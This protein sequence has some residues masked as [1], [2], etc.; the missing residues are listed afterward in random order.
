MGQAKLKNKFADE[1]FIQLSSLASNPDS[2]E[3]F[4]N[5]LNT[6]G[7]STTD[8]AKF[9]TAETTYLKALSHE[10]ELVKK[11]LTSFMDKFLSINF[12]GENSAIVSLFCEIQLSHND[13]IS[14]F[15]SDGGLNQAA[16]TCIG[17]ENATMHLQPF[18]VT[19]WAKP[20]GARLAES[21][22]VWNNVFAEVQNT[23]LGNEPAKL[24]LYGILNFKINA[25]FLKVAKL[26]VS[27]GF[28]F[29]TCFKVPYKIGDNT[30]FAEVWPL[31]LGLP[32]STSIDNAFYGSQVALSE[33]IVS[34]N[35]DPAD[36]KADIFVATNPSDPARTKV[37]VANLISGK[38]D[39]KDP[40]RQVAFS[41]GSDNPAAFTA[42]LEE[43][44]VNGVAEVLYRNKTIIVAGQPISDSIKFVDN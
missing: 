16:A 2:L 33:L 23:R 18:G 10:S 17:V 37:L 9:K 30:Y 4:D 34:N 41:K 3:I 38:P 5:V 14:R 28:L 20:F 42:L 25:S 1:I 26:H 43:L 40:V 27:E 8:K 44:K 35:L 19:P 7:A 31:E 21:A 11:G 15:S 29:D 36:T 24:P 6:L 22:A 32:F 13:G 12:E 39:P